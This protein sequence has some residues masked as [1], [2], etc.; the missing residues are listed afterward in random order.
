MNKTSFYNFD[1]ESL[2]Q[3]LIKQNIKPYTAKQLFNWVYKKN[4]KDFK[5]MTNIGKDNQVLLDSLLIFDQLEIV[6]V[7][8]DENKETIKFT[9]KAK[10]PDFTQKLAILIAYVWLIC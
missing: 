4:V 7:L 5:Q 3:W 2:E 1:L 6:N 10:M 8:T 9:N